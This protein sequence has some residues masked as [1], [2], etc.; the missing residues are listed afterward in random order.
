MLEF[1]SRLLPSERDIYT[2]RQIGEVLGAAGGQQRRVLRRLV[3]AKQVTPLNMGKPVW[4]VDAPRILYDVRNTGLYTDLPSI[5]AHLRGPTVEQQ[6]PSS[7]PLDRDLYTS[8]ELA[9]HMLGAGAALTPAGVWACVKPL[10]K[11]GLV[12]T[13]T[14]T[15][16]VLWPGTYAS[17]HWLYSVRNHA[18]WAGEHEAIYAVL[19]RLST[20][21]LTHKELTTECSIGNATK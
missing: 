6:A 7:L 12:R 17:A 1:D 20:R 21:P 14:S 19:G 18:I 5:R 10:H 3:A 9:L 2:G 8:V 15:G 11:Q 16:W 13:P 4:Y